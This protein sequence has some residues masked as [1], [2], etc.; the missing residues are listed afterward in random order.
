MN[1]VLYSTAK[2][3]VVSGLKYL[4]F[5]HY[6]NIFFPPAS[7]QKAAHFH[8][9]KITYSHRAVLLQIGF[10]LFRITF[11]DVPFCQSTGVKIDNTAHLSSLSALISCSLPVFCRRVF[12]RRMQCEGIG[13]ILLI[14]IT[15]AIYLPLLVM[16]TVPSCDKICSILDND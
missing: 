9:S 14:G 15:L 4:C 13:T 2:L 7:C 12:S 6:G 3:I 8:H 11:I 5:K 10:R 1:P 16:V